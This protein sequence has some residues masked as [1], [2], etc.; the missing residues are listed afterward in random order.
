MTQFWINNPSILLKH[1][2]LKY[3][4]PTNMMSS[5]EKLNAITRLVLY[6]TIIS[7][8]FFEERIKFLLIGLVTIIVVVGLYYI[9]KDKQVKEKNLIEGFNSNIS[10]NEWTMPKPNN[11][12]MNV[13]PTEILDNPTRKSRAQ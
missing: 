6:L 3:F 11:P 2:N 1:N 7:C 12:A 10:K 5:N 4:W 9:N 8:I 13:L